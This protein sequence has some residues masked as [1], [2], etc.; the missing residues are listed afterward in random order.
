MLSI[1]CKYVT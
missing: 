1:R